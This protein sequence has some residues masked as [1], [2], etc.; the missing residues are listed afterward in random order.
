ML[1]IVYKRKLKVHSIF[2]SIQT[3]G[4]NSGR[5]SVFVN[6]F[7]PNISHSK[8]NYEVLSTEEIVNR[9]VKKQS[10]DGS[11][12]CDFVLVNSSDIASIQDLYCLVTCLRRRGFKYVALSTSGILHIHD[13][14][15]D[16]ISILP[17]Y[18]NNFYI[19]KKN[20]PN[21]L[22]YIVDDYF[23]PVVVKDNGCSLIYIQP[24]SNKESFNKAIRVVKE[25]P[26]WLLTIK[27]LL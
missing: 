3:E 17:Q 19:H 6:L 25:N 20:R 13:G 16:W 26:K 9:C 27:R 14:I 24:Q 10:N 23:T 11:I 15:F 4:F 12:K 5:A 22:R 8:N 2:Y 1:D 18:N 21:E 7:D